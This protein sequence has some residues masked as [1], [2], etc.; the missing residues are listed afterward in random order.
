MKKILITLCFASLA[1]CSSSPPNEP[2]P[3]VTTLASSPAPRTE[4]PL[5]EV[6]QEMGFKKPPGSMDLAVQYD[7][8]RQEADKSYSFISTLHPDRTI[9]TA[10]GYEPRTGDH[11]LISTTGGKTF[12]LASFY[13][14]VK[15]PTAALDKATIKAKIEQVLGKATEQ[16]EKFKKDPQPRATQI[17]ER[18]AN[19]D[20]YPGCRLNL[21]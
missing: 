21:T 5:Q 19:L 8:Y 9:I 20:D 2:P 12:R 6:L 7:W 13:C 16:W 11:K 1:A 10:G 3:P 18:L 17:K 14:T 4:L 15:E